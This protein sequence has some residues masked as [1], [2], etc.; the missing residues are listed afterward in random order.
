MIELPV[1]PGIDARWEFIT[2]AVAESL[3]ATQRKN[4][5]L[6][7]HQVAML[8]RDFMNGNWKYENPQTIGIDEFGNLYDGQH[9]LSGLVRANKQTI[10][11]G[12]SPILGVW[13]LVARGV[14]SQIFE[15]TDSGISRAVSDVFKLQFGEKNAIKYIALLRQFYH[16]TVH[17]NYYMKV[18]N[19]TM[20]QFRAQHQEALA[21]GIEYLGK[22][23]QIP[24]PV[25]AAVA[26]V[27][28]LLPQSRTELT[29]FADQL[30]TGLELS[31]GSPVLALRKSLLKVSRVRDKQLSFYALSAIRHY[32]LQSKIT[33]L[34]LKPEIVEYF[35]E[36][37]RNQQA[38]EEK[39]KGE[40][41]K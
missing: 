34:V 25:W 37:S 17:P 24:S 30:L 29:A 12:K 26:Y 16:L 36:R 27:W 8:A 41:K 14:P 23:R 39:V 31:E 3:L 9:R 33:N 21:W 7:E 13:F 22:S 40:S 38:K 5:T 2:P 28:E 18:S 1:K 6:R 15:V 4:R 11:A 32:L 20:I 19:E 10:E 35:R